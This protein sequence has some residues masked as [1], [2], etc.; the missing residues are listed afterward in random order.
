MARYPFGPYSRERMV[1]AITS[2]YKFLRGMHSNSWGACEFVYPPPTGWPDITSD[3]FPGYDDTV[4]DLVRHLPYIEQEELLAVP[5]TPIVPYAGPGDMYW[6]RG[7]FKSRQEEKKKR[8]DVSEQEDGNGQKDEN[9]TRDSNPNSTHYLLEL[10]RGGQ[11]GSTIFVDTKHNAV[12]WW[13]YG[14]G[15]RDIPQEMQAKY[16]C[17]CW[18]WYSKDEVNESA[19]GEE[20][21]PIDQYGSDAWKISPAYSPEDFFEMCKEQ[22][23]I[24]NWMPILNE[25]GRGGIIE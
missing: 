20:F 23:R 9:E 16:P 3:L 22:F 10:A 18:S 7:V 17:G 13:Q 5:D 24:M 14:D 19:D 21:D 11:Y 1:A 25:D 8:Q 15:C 12:I 2:F 6:R 4:L